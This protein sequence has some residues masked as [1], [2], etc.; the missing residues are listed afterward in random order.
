M[1]IEKKLEM[2]LYKIA[3][4]YFGYIQ[5][6]FFSD[7]EQSN[8]RF[9][10]DLEKSHTNFMISLVIPFNSG[11]QPTDSYMDKCEKI[12]DYYDQILKRSGTQ[13]ID[14]TR[15]FLGKLNALLSDKFHSL[16]LQ[17]RLKPFTD[18]DIFIIREIQNLHK[19]VI[20]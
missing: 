9:F 18:L 2:N 13:R 14:R 4:T 12:L 5:G 15:K 3:L 8:S 6:A 19:Q 11:L 7:I 17:Q 20:E 1:G 10:K 16:E